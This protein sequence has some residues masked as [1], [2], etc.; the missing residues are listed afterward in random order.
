M[1]GTD[2]STAVHTW[3]LWMMACSNTASKASSSAQIFKAATLHLYQPTWRLTSSHASP[4]K[5]S[6]SIAASALSE[7]WKGKRK[8]LSPVYVLVSILS[9]FLIFC[10]CLFFSSSFTDQVFSYSD[11]NLENKNF[12]QKSQPTNNRPPPPPPPKIASKHQLGK[13]EPAKQFLSIHHTTNLHT[14]ISQNVEYSKWM[15]ACQPPQM[16]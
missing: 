6:H 16:G 2:W 3:A 8:S 13:K 4:T 9:F 14:C 15:V 5:S 1:A 10:F 7:P 12:M 11:P